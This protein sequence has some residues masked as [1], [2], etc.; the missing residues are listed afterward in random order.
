M[1]Y[2]LKVSNPLPDM[3][4]IHRKFCPISV[5]REFFAFLDLPTLGTYRLKSITNI[6]QKAQTKYWLCI[7]KS[8][9]SI[10]PAKITI[11]TSDSLDI[12]STYI[13]TPTVTAIPVTKF[14]G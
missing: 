5:Y 14:R 11:S 3:Y 8:I 12:D 2:H 9:K 13:E 10:I 6:D 7:I 4:L 1:L